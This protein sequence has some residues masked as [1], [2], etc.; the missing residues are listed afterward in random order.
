[1]KTLG[2]SRRTHPS[3]LRAPGTVGCGAWTSVVLLLV[4]FLKQTATFS[5]SPTTIVSSSG[6]RIALFRGS[7][8]FPLKSRGENLPHK[9]SPYSSLQLWAAASKD[10]KESSGDRPNNKIPLPQ[11]S[12]WT[13]AECMRRQTER[14]LLEQLVD[15]DDAIAEIRRL[16]FSERGPSVQEKMYI[17]EKSIGNPENWTRAE[18]ILEE[19]IE[20]D[21]TYIEPFVRLSKLYCLQGRFEESERICQAVIEHRPW[22]FVAAE[23]M[24]ALGRVRKNEKEHLIRRL[25]VPSKK[26]LR[27]AWVEQA[28]KDSIAAELNNQGEEDSALLGSD[29]SSSWQ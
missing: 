24:A 17:A 9:T 19:L 21:P 11:A 16:W 7:F 12:P 1:M 10:E 14:R 22:H 5:L 29:N 23:T 13:T 2:L 18:T 4:L 27:K 28:V 15:G 3:S 20:D 6:R 25:P 26:E 8:Q